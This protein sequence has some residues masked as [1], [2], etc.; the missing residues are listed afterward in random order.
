MSLKSPKKGVRW[1]FY[2]L[3]CNPLFSLF[4]KKR[5]KTGLHDSNISHKK[6]TSIWHGIRQGRPCK[7][8]GTWQ[9]LC[10]FHT[11]NL[12]RG[13]WQ[14]PKADY[15]PGNPGERRGRWQ[16]QRQPKSSKH[17]ND[18]P[19]NGNRCGPLPLSD[20]LPHLP[21]GDPT[22]ESRKRA[23][24]NLLLT[25]YYLLLTTYY[26]LLTTYYLDYSEPPRSL[27]PF[28]ALG[29]HCSTC[30]SV[31]VHVCTLSSRC[32]VSRGL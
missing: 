7:N 5:L 28:F 32:W 15:V 13:T 22:T 16:P 20:S 27:F 25:T 8:R 14:N 1:Q 10:W 18:L 29:L 9:H 17:A 6:M 19:R 11:E 2:G 26:L 3:S 12:I 23:F 21:D 31:R 4:Y 24:R 30:P